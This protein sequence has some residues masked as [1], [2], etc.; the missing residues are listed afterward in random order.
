MP[1]FEVAGPELEAALPGPAPGEL[2]PEPGTRVHA[3]RALRH[4]QF[5]LLFSA[6]SIGD[7]G[8]WIS[9]I[10]IQAEMADITDKSASWLGILYFANFI[11][12]LLWSPL[13]GVVAD[14]VDRKLLLV[15]IRSVIAVIGAAL[16]LLILTGLATPGVLV[17]MAFLLG[18]TYGFLGPAQTAAVANTV[19]AD[20]L[21]SAVSMAS[22]GNNLCR[23]AGPALAAPILAV[24]GTGWAFAVYAASQ[25]TVAL[26]LLPV[27]LTSTLDVHSPYGAFRRWVDGL[28]HARERPPALAA[29]LT[30]CVFS[31]F[32]GAQM[33]LYP[34]F[35]SEV[36]DRPTSA[37]TAIIVASAIGAVLGAIGN[38]LR[39]TV[40]GLR[41]PLLWLVGFGVASIGFA[42][43]GTW[44]ACLAFAVLVGFCY[45]SMTTALNTMLQH[46]ADD[47]KR[48]RMMALF[49]VT[50]GGVI[51][52]GAIWMG[53]LAD[54]TSAPFV[55]TFGAAVCLVYAAAQLLR[56]TV[57]ARAGD[58]PS[59]APLR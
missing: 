25:A 54:A 56:L 35:A 44:T 50:W 15:A 53:A 7:V 47:E 16:A 5:T 28:R 57:R 31:I 29:L 45:F 58:Q 4:R 48:G 41:S 12:M 18:S 8:Y 22:A 26:L 3:F 14:R 24:W 11:P 34:I 30:M 27:H 43:A 1:E 17:V 42:R 46:L 32:G 38:G 9:F 39:R 40:P 36:H 23:I 13:A 2:A 19:P 52:I 21:T 59:T 37:F 55:V 33:A 10:A 20:D 51:P 6:S 49:V